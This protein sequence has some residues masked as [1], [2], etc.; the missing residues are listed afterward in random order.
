[1]TGTI[2]QA[3]SGFTPGINYT[4]SFLAAERQHNAQ[5]WNVTVNGAVLASFNPGANATSYGDCTA[6]FTATAATQ[7]VAFVG[8]DLAGGDNTVFIDNVRIT[9][10][11]I[12]PPVN[13]NI[14]QAGSHL[15]LSW[16]QGLLLQAPHVTG[17]WTTNNTTSPY[18]NQPDTPQMFYRVRVQ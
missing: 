9:A 16:P 14:Q 11:P 6:T 3:I 18:T 1:M 4:V 8:T 13:I 7:T 10:P 12:V 17:P 5:S 15:V 2:S